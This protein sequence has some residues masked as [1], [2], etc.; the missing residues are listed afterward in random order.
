MREEERR[1]REEERHAKCP[2]EKDIVVGLHAHN[3]INSGL[4][5][6]PDT[7][8]GFMLAADCWQDLG[9]NTGDWKWSRR[10][11]SGCRRST[12]GGKIH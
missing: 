9:K 5:L 11:A 1:V 8:Q 12:E 6:R 3:N 4:L 7:R 2:R 10:R